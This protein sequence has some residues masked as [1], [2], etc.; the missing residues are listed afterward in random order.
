MLYSPILSNINGYG[1]Y[2]TAGKVFEWCADWYDKG[3]YS[4]S[5]KDNPKG[6]DIG[7]TRVVRGGG[8][9]YTANFLRVADRFGSYFPSNAYPFVGFRCAK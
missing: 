2:D 9:G 5:Q 8:F 1:L 6:P 4:K 3:Y 7:T